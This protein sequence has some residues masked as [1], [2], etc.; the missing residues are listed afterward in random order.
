MKEC[1]PL[2]RH[3][4]DR[5]DAINTRANTQKRL[6]AL[7]ALKETEWTDKK[8]TERISEKKHL[9]KFFTAT[10]KD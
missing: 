9:T 2:G 8:E 5:S 7:G 6:K 10:K 3:N 4:T 1:I